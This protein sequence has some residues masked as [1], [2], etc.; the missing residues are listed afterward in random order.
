[1]PTE[2]R[3]FATREDAARWRHAE[4]LMDAPIVPVRAPMKFSWCK[5]TGR[6]PGLTMTA[7]LVTIFAHRRFSPA[8]DRAC[9]SL[10]EAALHDDWK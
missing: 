6:L 10:A 4:R 3:V 5:S 2:E 7:R 1:M 8:P 9:L